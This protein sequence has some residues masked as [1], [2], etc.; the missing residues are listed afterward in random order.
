MIS[1]IKMN[2][3]R[4][5]KKIFVW[6]FYEKKISILVLK[7]SL[8]F[9]LF[10]IE[11]ST[12][13][14]VISLAFVYEECAAFAG[15]R[16]FCE[17]NVSTLSSQEI[18]WTSPGLSSSFPTSAN[19]LFLVGLF[20]L[21]YFIRQFRMFFLPGAR[22][23]SS[24]KHK[25]GENTHLEGVRGLKALGVRD[26][27][28]RL[29]FLACHIELTS[30]ANGG[31]GNLRYEDMSP[32]ELQ[33]ALLPG[34]LEK[35]SQ[36]SEDPDLYEKILQSMFPTIYGI[37]LDWLID[38]FS[39]VRCSVCFIRGEKN[40]KFRVKKKH[41][42]IN[43]STIYWSHVLSPTP[44]NHEIKRGILLMLLGG[45]GKVTKSGTH[46]RGDINVCVVGDPSTAK[47]QFLR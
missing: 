1:P 23:E 29:A 21:I 19:W 20:L 4:G 41:L 43:S 32:E 33:K 25:Q 45:V 5:R 2:F 8:V 42:P 31:V 46:L 15:S 38:W 12:Q 16:L 47:S 11:D 35:L 14:S 6:K 26:L 18:A 9:C 10:F 3:S 17:R 37:D 36:M 34:E 13:Q 7:K 39:G 24:A 30:S 27:T 28:Y 40:W 44:G 22:A